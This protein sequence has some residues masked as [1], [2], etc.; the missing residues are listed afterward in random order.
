MANQHPAQ[1]AQPAPHVKPNGGPSDPPQPDVPPQMEVGGSG[2]AKVSFKDVNGADVKIVSS[3]W[4]STGPVTVTADATDPASATLVSTASGRAH[5]KADVVSE[6]GSPAEAAV[7]IRVVETGTPAEGKIELTFE[8]AKATKAK[9]AAKA[10]A[11][12]KPA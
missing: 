7:E 1:H 2:T 8:T 11:T 3:T 10:A 9:V 12:A 5:V 4:T 6:A